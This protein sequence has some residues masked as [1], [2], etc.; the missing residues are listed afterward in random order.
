[1]LPYKFPGGG[2][3]AGE[4][5]VAALLRE[6]AEEAGLHIR[7]ETVRAYGYVHRIQRSDHADADVFLQDNFYYLCETEPAPIA[8]RLD[9]YEADEGFTLVEP[10]GKQEE[11]QL[12]SPQQA[13]EPQGDS[14]QQ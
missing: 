4:E 3:E 7:P 14:S 5:P 2:I 1:M 13:S 11:P 9:D 6:T 10:V 8:Q 12:A